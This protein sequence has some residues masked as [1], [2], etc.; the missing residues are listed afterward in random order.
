MHEGKTTTAIN[1]AL[2]L[3]QIGKRVLLMDVDFRN[4][5]IHHYFD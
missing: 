2:T 5:A 1:L 3:A 4:P